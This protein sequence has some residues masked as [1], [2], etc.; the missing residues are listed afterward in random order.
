[1]RLPDFFKLLAVVGFVLVFV[2]SNAAVAQVPGEPVGVSPTPDDP[3]QF[4][5]D[6]DNIGVP[7]GVTPVDADDLSA[8]IPGIDGMAYVYQTFKPGAAAPLVP[9]PPVGFHNAVLNP[10]DLGLLR[11]VPAPLPSRLPQSHKDEV[12]A[13]SY[14]Q[15]F[16]YPPVL[17]NPLPA[18]DTPFAFRDY[19]EFPEPVVGGT[20]MRIEFSVD[21]HAK[22]VAGS[23]VR[24]VVGPFPLKPSSHV[25]VSGAAGAN[26]VLY[27]DLRLAVFQNDDVDAYENVPVPLAP[28]HDPDDVAAAA[29]SNLPRV[30]FSVDNETQ[31]YNPMLTGLPNAVNAQAGLGEASGDVFVGIGGGNLLLIDEMQLGLWPGMGGA[32]GFDD[33]DDLDALALNIL[34]TDAELKVRIDDAVRDFVP[35]FDPSQPDI[36]GITQPLLSAKEALVLFSVEEG[37]IGRQFTAVDFEHRIDFS[38]ESGDLF[39]SNLSGQNWLAYEATQLGLLESDELD[40]LDTAAVPE[41]STLAMLAALGLL[42][43]AAVVRKRRQAE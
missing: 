2:L 32:A 42:G 38:Q 31:G 23:G 1:M 34:I 22:G 8:F 25:F 27:S 43:L 40:A 41:P 19:L 12:N 33:A 7:N 37:S 18:E 29:N 20:R 5:L 17:L 15:D 13:I 14:G 6:E 39:F 35:D 10:L 4:S 21:V 3:K 11:N 24:G 16:F 26:S 36:L 9:S 28:L 30:F